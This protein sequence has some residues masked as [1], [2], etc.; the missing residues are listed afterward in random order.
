MYYNDKFANLMKQ[1]DIPSVPMSKEFVNLHDAARESFKEIAKGELEGFVFASIYGAIKF[2]IE[3]DCRD[4]ILNLIDDML[5]RLKKDKDSLDQD[6]F[7]NSFAP[8]FGDHTSDAS[9]LFK[10]YKEIE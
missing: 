1:N 4:T 7:L 6:G 10:K 9:K 5:N 3:S 2:E 8:I